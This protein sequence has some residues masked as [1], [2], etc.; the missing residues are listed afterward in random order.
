M[1]LNELDAAVDAF[2]HAIVLKP[3]D[4]EIQAYSHF[5][6]GQI[7]EQR[8]GGAEAIAAFQNVLSIATEPSLKEIRTEA[9]HHLA[10]IYENGRPM[11]ESS[12]A[13]PVSVDLDTALQL[14]AEVIE[15]NVNLELTAEALY[16]SGA[17]HERRDE[18]DKATAAFSKLT[19][20]FSQTTQPEIKAMVEDALLRLPNLLSRSGNAD[21]AIQT[22]QQALAVAKQKAD[23]LLFAQAQFQ[24]ATLYYQNGDDKQRKEAVKLFK[25]AYQNALNVPKPDATTVALINAAMFQAGQAAYQNQ[26]MLSAIKPLEEFIQR[27]PEDQKIN[28]AYEY[29]AWSYF[30]LAD[31]TKSGKDRATRFTKAAD[32]FDQLVARNA[33]SEKA[34][35]W[36]YQSA[37][38]LTFAG[39]TP[40][41]II[42]HQKLV[43]GYPKHDLADD[44]LYTV[45]GTQLES[46][47]YDEALKTYQQLVEGYADSEWV[48]ESTYAIA[49][50]HEKLGQTETALQVYQTVIER[51]P[52]KVVAANAQVNIAHHH[53]NRK[54]YAQALAAYRKLTKKNFPAMD[55]K[56]QNNVRRW[57]RDTENILVE[58]PY[59]AAVA[60]LTKADTGAET[61]SDGEKK[62]ALDAIRQFEALIKNYPHCAYVDYALASIGAAHEIREDWDGALKAYKQLTSRY[63]KNPPSDANVQK[64]VDY[65]QGR[66]EDIKVFLLQKQK[67]EN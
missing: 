14:Y 25:G 55:N 28:A 5:Y 44:S 17:I 23:P 40:M 3:N 50:C 60:L 13:T 57:R 61:A 62:Y 12:A 49:T 38:A 64:M 51:F 11:D 58:K 52:D 53:F 41:G 67:F 31:Q 35:G 45:G 15:A 8:K 18:P 7:H 27:F 37:L 54:D 19:S 20:R 2:E 9:T 26:E 39:N 65:A 22:A 43:E 10:R 1:H 42:A 56:L 24:L 63:K 59:K 16:R 33:D 36:I 4:T 32:A 46:K 47:Q 30:T 21:T 34:P 29:L 66:I 48:D 6:L